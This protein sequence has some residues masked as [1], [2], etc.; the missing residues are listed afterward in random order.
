MLTCVVFFLSRF[1]PTGPTACNPPRVLDTATVAWLVHIRLHWS[2]VS[3]TRHIHQMKH[4]DLLLTLRKGSIAA[5]HT[6]CCQPR[7]DTPAPSLLSCLVP[8]GPLPYALHAMPCVLPTREAGYCWHTPCARPCRVMSCS[9][10][11]HVHVPALSLPSLGGR[12]LHP[13]VGNPQPG[14]LGLDSRTYILVAPGAGLMRPGLLPVSCRGF[15]HGP[16]LPPAIK[17]LLFR[18]GASMDNR[19]APLPFPP[20]VASPPPPTHSPAHPAQE[21]LV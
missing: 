16:A 4:I 15:H 8:P 11:V 17:V 1:P 7:Y 9:T 6:T 14:Q 3:S 2:N 12:G 10:H 13:R 21:E 18:H 19:G 5:A 20:Q